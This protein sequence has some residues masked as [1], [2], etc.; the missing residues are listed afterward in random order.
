MKSGNFCWPCDSVWLVSPSPARRGLYSAGSTMLL[1]LKTKAPLA[2]AASLMAFFVFAFVRAR[3]SESYT[4]IDLGTLPGFEESRPTA[5]NN[6]GQ[7]VGWADGA[8]E[9]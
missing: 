3:S 8:D 6:L 9:N 5:I 2:S 4:L 1:R 7:V